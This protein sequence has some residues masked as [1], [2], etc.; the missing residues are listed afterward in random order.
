MGR[1][2]KAR[3]EHGERAKRRREEEGGGERSEG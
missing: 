2:Q 1:E 3:A